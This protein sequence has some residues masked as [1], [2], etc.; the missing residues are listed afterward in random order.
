MSLFDGMSN[1]LSSVDFDL[2]LPDRWS[3][4]RFNLQRMKT[5]GKLES[6]FRTI[7]SAEN[8]QMLATFSSSEIPSVWNGRQVKEQWTYLTRNQVNQKRLQTVIASELDLA[9]RLKAGAE[10][11]RH[12]VLFARL[13][14]EEI[15]I[16]LRW[17]RFSVIDNRNL[18]ALVEKDTEALSLSL[19]NFGQGWTLSGESITSAGVKSEINDLCE[20]KRDSM[21]LL[22]SVKREDAI[23]LGESLA[24]HLSQKLSQ[25]LP[26]LGLCLW[27]EENDHCAL[28]DT[29]EGLSQKVQDSLAQ[30]TQ[31]RSDKAEASKQRASEARERTTAKVEAEAAWRRLNAKRKA[32]GS[33]KT[34]SETQMTAVGDVDEKNAG[35][36][37]KMERRPT[38]GAPKKSSTAAGVSRKSNKDA[39]KGEKV[40]RGRKGTSKRGS[41][42]VKAWKDGESCTLQRGLFAGKL[43]T[44]VGTPKDGYAKVR[45]GVIEVSVKLTELD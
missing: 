9:E 18:L 26:L 2:Y 21:T 19:E 15:A 27:S 8:S 3:D 22:T 37:N 40:A 24:Q 41:Q 20:G 34:S 45:V 32:S 38:K 5:K 35:R 4:N 29:L 42:P 36:A 28:S 7:D 25:C 12:L 33:T 10:H 23:E 30:V 16:G 31:E 13:D 43:G 6:F 39:K 11:E 44:I 1:D 14:A 17:T